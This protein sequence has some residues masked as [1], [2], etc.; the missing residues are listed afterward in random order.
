MALQKYP[1]RNPSS[2]HP[3]AVGQR[4]FLAA[5]SGVEDPALGV[6]LGDAPFDTFVIDY[7]PNGFLD[8]QRR[9]LYGRLGF[10]DPTP[11][12]P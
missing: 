2:A 10:G 3:D 6:V 1:P 8:Y 7:G 4:A 12:R 11:R 5:V 9:D